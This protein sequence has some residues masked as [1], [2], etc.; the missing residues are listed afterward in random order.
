MPGGGSADEGHPT[1][2]R[3]LN[4]TFARP[5]LTALAVAVL[6][7]AAAGCATGAASPTQAATPSPTPSPS[8]SPVFVP[9]GTQAP[10]AGPDLS[11]VAA[12]TSG[13][14][15]P[16]Y[17]T[18]VAY[19]HPIAVMIDDAAGARP[20]SGLS[21]ADIVYQ[22]PAEGGVPRYMAL[23]QT[24]I[25]DWIGP[26]RST[27]LYYV[28][29][30]EEWQALY[31]H[32]LGAPNA[33]TRLAQIDG[34][35]VYNA[36]CLRW[37]RYTERVDYHAA[38]HNLYISGAN[39]LTVAGKVGATAPF[40]QTPFTFADDLA[41]ADRGTGGTLVV[42]YHAN[43][44]T[45]RY[46]PATN[47]YPRA[48]SGQDPQVDYGNK[49]PIAPRNVIVLYQETGLLPVEVG[50]AS[51][52]RLEINYLGSGKAAVYNNGQAIEATWSKKTESSPTLLTYASGPNEGRPVP[53]VRGQIFIQVVPT[54]TEV[55]W[56]PAGAASASP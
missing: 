6:T 31:V 40:S 35:Y 24:Q 16:W 42:P 22:A 4:L 51:K 2:T 38:P 46:D 19:R 14:L 29:W 10:D 18:A 3:K 12:P 43:T 50:Q 44:I 41:A 48:V 20:Q 54:D 36:D 5:L 7:S 53:M 45:Y 13:V 9:A 49:Q 47:T 1:G 56:T 30:A 34:K 32:M 39:V 21:L 25:P 11:D 8:P 33:I 37:L 52:G 55:T 23:F 28:A 15:Y 27:R 26:I 17:E